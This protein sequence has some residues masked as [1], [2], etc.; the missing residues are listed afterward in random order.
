MVIGP[1]NAG[2]SKFLREIAGCFHETGEKENYI[3]ESIEFDLPTSEEVFNKSYDI[4]NKKTKDEHGNIFLRTFFNFENF[5][6]YLNYNINKASFKVSFI[7]SKNYRY[8]FGLLWMF[9]S[10]LSWYR[11]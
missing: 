9:I 2:K 11:E 5:R 7:D 8:F 10:E 3:L 1:N 4:D 6:S